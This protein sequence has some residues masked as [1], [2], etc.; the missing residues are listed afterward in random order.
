MN[1]QNTPK[2]PPEVE[3]V[4]RGMLP[5]PDREAQLQAALLELQ[6]QLFEISAEK[7]RWRKLHDEQSLAKSLASDRA[8]CA[9]SRANALALKLEAS[10]AECRERLARNQELSGL[11]CNTESRVRELEDRGRHV[12][13]EVRRI[14]AERAEIGERAVKAGER[15][16]ELEADLETACRTKSQRALD[17]ESEARALRESADRTLQLWADLASQEMY[18]ELFMEGME[19]QDFEQ[20]IDQLDEL[21]EAAHHG[22]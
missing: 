4:L 10:E 3:P 6:N 5:A 17:A 2:H 18:G 21:R 16:L 19:R 9:E 12:D 8:A 13:G 7:E 11:L 1:N 22:S 20:W 14:C 15:I